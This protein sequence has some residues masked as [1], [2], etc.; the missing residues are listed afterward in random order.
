MTVLQIDCAYAATVDD[1]DALQRSPVDMFKD[2]LDRQQLE[3]IQ[4]GCPQCFSNLQVSLQRL[5]KLCDS[6]VCFVNHEQTVLLLAVAEM[7][8]S[9]LC[10]R[11]HLLRLLRAG[12]V[13]RTDGAKVWQL[14]QHCGGLHPASNAEGGC[15]LHYL[16][17]LRFVCGVAPDFSA[18]SCLLAVQRKLQAIGCSCSHCNLQ[19]RAAIRKE[20][21]GAVWQHPRV[22]LPSGP[23]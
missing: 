8:G 7:R 18:E 5:L 15:L 23:P 9:I 3:Q 16:S 19:T 11:S 10:F 4:S 6:L 20:Q 13:V 12:N 1:D 2:T 22:L 17:H 14:R 21:S